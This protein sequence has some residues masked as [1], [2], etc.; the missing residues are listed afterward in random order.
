[1]KSKTSAGGLGIPV[2]DAKS[3]VNQAAQLLL[4]RAV[5]EDDIVYNTQPAD[6]AQSLWMSSVSLPAMDPD[7][8]YQG[9][10][11][12]DKKQAE[13]SAAQAF[14]EAFAD[15]IEEAKAAREARLAERQSQKGGGKKGKNDM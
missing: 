15:H 10:C 13:A 2:G 9:E 8:W 3:K 11:C 5:T 1:M 12:A 4:H 14:L 7:G 6:E